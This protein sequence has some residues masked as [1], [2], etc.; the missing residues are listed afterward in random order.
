P[1]ADVPRRPK[2]FETPS[3]RSKRKIIKQ[4]ID[5]AARKKEIE[6][7]K[8]AAAARDAERKSPRQPKPEWKR[9]AKHPGKRISPPK[10]RGPFKKR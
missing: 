8:A 2:R 5:E 1:P 7:E 9:G 6:K 4:S 10:P 3:D